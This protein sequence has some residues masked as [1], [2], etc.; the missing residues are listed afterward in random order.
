MSP[1]TARSAGT[2]PLYRTVADALRREIR[3]TGAKPHARIGSQRELCERFKISTTTAEAVLD[4]LV[5]EGLI[6]RVRSKGAFVAPPAQR[7]EGWRIGVI[8][9]AGTDWDTNLYARDLYRA[10][11]IH[12]RERGV[13]LRFFELEENYTLLL[14]HGLVD[15]ILI[16]APFR[17]NLAQLDRLAE[18]RKPYLVVGADWGAHPSI[19]VDN[20][21][22]VTRAL[23]HLESLGHSRIALLTDPLE[24]SSDTLHRWEAYRDFFHRKRGGINP[25]W[26]LH[27]PDWNILGQEEGDRLFY[28]FFGEG[29]PPTAILA[30]GSFY[31]QNVA[32]ILQRHG[33][34]VP[35]DVSIVGCDLP[36]VG[37]EIRDRLTAI[38]QPVERLGRTALDMLLD[39]LEGRPLA[40]NRRL[41]ETELRLSA[42]TGPCCTADKALT[43]S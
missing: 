6:Y 37:I 41:L 14:D 22:G 34:S 30:L 12:A 39:H 32:Q 21:G 42:T 35:E 7:K 36:P 17:H 27:W 8:G 3:S 43:T 19:A 2:P 40:T 18:T 4:E 28:A 20:A 29:D 26:V 31:A 25:R 38:L 33:L 13:Y 16:L 10:I 24:S 1:R 5:R 11:Q 23:E 9:H 15:G